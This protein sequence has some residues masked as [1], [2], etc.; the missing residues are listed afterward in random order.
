M[1]NAA[2]VMD[3]SQFRREG[4]EHPGTW[5]TWQADIIFLARD[6]QAEAAVVSGLPEKDTMARNV[7][8][9]HSTAA[10]IVSHA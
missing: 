6:M 7:L 3:V 8:S 2:E 1:R 4:L 9:K 5:R 10:A